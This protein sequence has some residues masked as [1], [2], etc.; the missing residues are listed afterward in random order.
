MSSGGAFHVRILGACAVGVLTFALLRE[1]MG[2]LTR[3]GIWSAWLLPLSAGIGSTYLCLLLAR[4]REEGREAAGAMGYGEAVAELTR[5]LELIVDPQQLQ[6]A[7]LG[8]IGELFGADG[9][10]LFLRDPEGGRFTFRGQVG[11]EGFSLEEVAF[12]ERGRLAGW[13]MTNQAVLSVGRD[14]EVVEYLLEHE[15][16]VLERLGVDF[17][18]PFGAMNRLVGIALVKAG[19]MGLPKDLGFLRALSLQVGLALENALLY[20]QQKLRLRRLYRAER[21]ATVGQLAAGVA[22]EVRNPLAIIS[23]TVQYLIGE[24]PPG[25]RKREMA[26][27]LLEEVDRIDQIVEGLLSF[28]RPAE[29]KKERVSIRELLE[30]TLLL[31]RTAAGKAGVE[32]ETDFPLGDDRMDLDPSQMKQVFL[33]VVVNAIQAMPQGGKLRI[34]LSRIEGGLLS[35]GHRFRIEFVDTG[36]GMSPE[37]LERAFDPFY[38]TKPDGTGLGLPISYSIV[39][40][41]GGEMDIESRPGKG[42]TVRIEL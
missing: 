22:H 8:R 23:S 9:V 24:F 19:D 15:R 3:P 18:L 13:L 11:Y 21:L 1:A 32:V 29:P 38:T 4:L 10:V 42:T 40:S 30:Q 36:V 20:E 17:C 5:S 41:H 28:A 39:K 37:Q 16:G 26:E 31:A 25:H 33:N 27:G 2:L 12:E 14:R 7:V 35:G 6:A 34:R